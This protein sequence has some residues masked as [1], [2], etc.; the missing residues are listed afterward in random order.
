VNSTHSSTGR[1][2]LRRVL[3]GRSFSHHVLPHAP[4]RS[5][6]H[7]VEGRRRRVSRVRRRL[8]RLV[9]LGRVVDKVSFEGG[10]VRVTGGYVE[11]DNRGEDFELSF[12][13]E[14]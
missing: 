2:D 8:F 3:V 12:V 9:F 7:L 10:D 11:L 4:A 13:V 5:D 14:G 1:R 6:S